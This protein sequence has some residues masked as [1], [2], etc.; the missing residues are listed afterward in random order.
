LSPPPATEPSP[1]VRRTQ[2]ITLALCLKCSSRAHGI[3]QD[4]RPVDLRDIRNWRAWKPGAYW[5]P[6]EGRGS[7]V[8]GR[9]D[10]PVVQIAFE[11]A[12][13]YAC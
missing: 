8:A 11:D 6:P 7:S 12:E 3:S 13:A 10:H 2:P 1:S 9:L 5:H 4:A